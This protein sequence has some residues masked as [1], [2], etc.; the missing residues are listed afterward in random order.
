MSRNSCEVGTGA[1]SFHVVFIVAV[2]GVKGSEWP[3]SMLVEL[4]FGQAKRK[5]SSFALPSPSHRLSSPS[6]RRT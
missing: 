6:P 4:D 3:V 5:S 1:M 2:S